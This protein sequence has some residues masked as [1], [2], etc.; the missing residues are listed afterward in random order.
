MLPLGD[1]NVRNSHPYRSCFKNQSSFSV[2]LYFRHDAATSQLFKLLL[3]LLAVALTIQDTIW[4]GVPAVVTQGT[5]AVWASAVLA[6]T[7]APSPLHPAV[8]LLHHVITDV[9]K[10][11]EVETM[12]NRAERENIKP[13]IEDDAFV[14]FRGHRNEN[15]VQ[16]AGIYLPC[17]PV[18]SSFPSGYSKAPSVPLMP[19]DGCGDVQSAGGQGRSLLDLSSN[20][21][22]RKQAEV[23]YL[24]SYTHLPLSLS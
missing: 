11:K 21:W 14:L 20:C 13:R 5:S 16:Q 19:L 24:C 10:H 23:M 4:A 8:L 6:L 2:A 17:R 12:R 7:A 18:L 1:A 3:S 9:G 15:C 22:C